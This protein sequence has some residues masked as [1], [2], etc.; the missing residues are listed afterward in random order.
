MLLHIIFNIIF[1]K[2]KPPVL[3]ILKFRVCLTMRS[4]LMPAFP[5]S[6]SKFHKYTMSQK[7]ITYSSVLNIKYIFLMCTSSKD[8]QDVHVI[9]D[10]TLLPLT[11]KRFDEEIIVFASSDKWLY[12]FLTIACANNN[13]LLV[14][15]KD[16]DY[17]N[18][19]E[20]IANTDKTEMCEI[21]F[22]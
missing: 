5:I 3:L 1:W 4:I 6:K 21:S 7:K 22:T 16:T 9:N 17:L 14:H 20:K 19:S 8:F 2:C 18:C 15:N 11:F 10:A 13:K 12:G